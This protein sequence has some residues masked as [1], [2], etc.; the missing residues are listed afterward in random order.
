MNKRESDK[1]CTTSVVLDK[2]IL[3]DF[4]KL[5][6]EMNFKTMSSFI[7]YLI[8]KELALQEKMTDKTKMKIIQ[9]I[10]KDI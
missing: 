6:E 8:N 9:N 4:E 5:K 7:R 3:E 1:Y 10:L 2:Q